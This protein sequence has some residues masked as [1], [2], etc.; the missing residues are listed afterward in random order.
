MQLVFTKTRILSV[1][2]ATL[3]TFLAMVRTLDQVCSFLWMHDANADKT[4]PVKS[5]TEAGTVVVQDSD[6][7]A[8]CHSKWRTIAGGNPSL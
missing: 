3:E 8:C 6:Q 1:K 4:C 5:D 2:V 7:R